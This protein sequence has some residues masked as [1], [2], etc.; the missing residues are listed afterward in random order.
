MT[1]NTVDHVE[2]FSIAV[3]VFN[4]DKVVTVT[5]RIS[6]V[7]EDPPTIACFR[8]HHQHCA[9][10]DAIAWTARAEYLCDFVLGHSTILLNGADG[11]QR[12]SANHYFNVTQLAIN[13]V[14]V[15]VVGVAVA[16]ADDV[17]VAGDADAVVVAGVA[18]VAAAVA[19]AVADPAGADAAVVWCKGTCAWYKG[20]CE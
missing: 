16:P 4:H 17:A 19:V 9:T 14:V 6:V 13:R 2:E 18:G 7:V 3:N 11:L 20:K 15:A 12:I 8:G 5:V 1:I 10:I